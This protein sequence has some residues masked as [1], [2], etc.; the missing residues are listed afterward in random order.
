M[1]IGF[2]QCS[3]AHRHL[4]ESFEGFAGAHF[5]PVRLPVTASRTLYD[6]IVVSPTYEARLGLA[7]TISDWNRPPIA[8]FTFSEEAY[9][10]GARQLLY[11][12]RTGRGV[13]CCLDD[14]TAIR[15]ALAEVCAFEKE[16]RRVVDEEGVLSTYHADNVSPRW[17]FEQLMHWMDEYIYFKDADSRFLAVSQYLIEQCNKTSPDEILGKTDF[18]FFDK[19][20]CDEAFHDERKIALGE[21]GEVH[22][23]ERLDEEDG[24]RWV[25]SR[26][27]PLMTRSDLIAGSFG[28]SRD[29]T[30]EKALKQSIIDNANRME[31]ELKLAHKLQTALQENAVSEFFQR[32]QLENLQLEVRYIPSFMLSGDFYTVVET[33]DGGIGV[34]LGD[35]MGHGV[36]A[37]LV[38]A[39]IQATTQQLKRYLHL[40]SSFLAELNTVIQRISVSAGSVLFSTAAYLYF[41]ASGTSVSI[42]QA[43]SNHG[44]RYHSQGTDPALP[45]LTEYI[46]PALGLL[47][48]SEFGESTYPIHEGDRLLLFTDGIIE[49]PRDGKDYGMKRLLEVAEQTRT[50]PVAKSLDRLI[51]TAKDYSGCSDFDDDVCLIGIQCG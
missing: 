26:K 51:A 13:F 21:M 18:E 30:E 43:G 16:R 6:V 24:V 8:L 38:T 42:A 35:V 41:D 39:M 23:E 10:E 27:L 48:D 11:H 44:I 20:H 15:E 1:Q 2:V 47:P 31:Q 33:P 37:A 36:R 14:E 25:Y 7:A 3:D 28:L 4:V 19:A 49:V 5:K 45:R 34:F 29:I 22:K 9:A 40:P 50:L 46:G 12:P 32:K 17:L